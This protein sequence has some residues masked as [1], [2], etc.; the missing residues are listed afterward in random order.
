MSDRLI[1]LIQ[2]MAKRGLGAALVMKRENIRYL[3]GYTGEG[4][5]LIA[6]GKAVVLTDFRYV[7]Q[8][9][10]EAG[11]TSVVRTSADNTPFMC[12]S[13]LLSDNAVD[14]LAIESDFMTVD[15]YGELKKACP[16][17]HF[18]QMGGAI[19]ALRTVKSPDEVDSIVRASK[20]A[21]RAF[22]E[23]L[24]VIRAGMTE[25]EVQLELDYRMIRLGADKVAFDTI[26]AAGLNGSLPHAVPTNHV[27]KEGELLTL[28]FGAEVNGYKCDMTRTLAL[29]EPRAELTHIYEAV[30]AAHLA[31]LDAVKPGA[32]CADV[33]RVARTM[34]DASYPGAFGH[35]LGHGVGLMIHEAP[36]LSMASDTVLT[37]GHVVTVE[38][39]VYVEGLG[40][41][42]IEDT[43]IVTKSG[44]LD[45]VYAP[46]HLINL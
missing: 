41:C 37:N 10:R 44:Y 25:K 42:R 12:V 38:P 4:M 29:G 27:L 23:M 13:R 20:I 15:A 14:T 45:P 9:S 5:L 2:V 8:V 31:A 24:G 16:D 43:V 19:E 1:R 32:K 34:L 36:S 22:E 17:V 33:D 46:K 35:S 21:C 28:D 40:G 7:E 6:G 30:L 39:G 3:T 11:D 18:D 26:A